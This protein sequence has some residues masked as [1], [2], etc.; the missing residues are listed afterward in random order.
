MHPKFRAGYDFLAL[1]AQAGE[2][3]SETVDW[4]T[5]FQTETVKQQQSMVDALGKEGS[6]KK[7]RRRRRRRPA[8]KKSEQN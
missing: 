1:R 3:L 4:W 7:P 6:V 2:P 5:K 8:A